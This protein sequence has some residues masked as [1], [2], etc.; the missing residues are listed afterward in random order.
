[1]KIFID[2]EF[3]EDGK[4]ID[5]I[6]IG[7][8]NED[9]EEYYAINLDCKF[10]RA[11]DWVKEN[12]FPPI[13]IKLEKEFNYIKFPKEKT[14]LDYYKNKPVIAK[15]VELF[16]RGNNGDRDI[17]IWCDYGHYDYVVICQLYGK[18]INLPNIFPYYFNDIQSLA[19]QLSR[20]KNYQ[21]LLNSILPED[22]EIDGN[23]N[24]LL[25]A[26]SCK[27]RYEY[28]ETML[29]S[30]QN[31]LSDERIDLPKFS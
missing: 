19:R 26:K 7:M 4:T 10:D 17:E 12:V 14:L 6:S 21:V 15:E 9:G 2:T 22:L 18:M 3:I 23:H 11:N 1:M 5:L 8:I 28:L 31:V 29:T 30:I 24:A 13:G 25:G 20:I 16:L 27:L